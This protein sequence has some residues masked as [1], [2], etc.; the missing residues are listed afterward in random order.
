MKNTFLLWT[1]GFRI[2]QSRIWFFPFAQ[3]LWTI[4]FRILARNESL[5]SA[6]LLWSCYPWNHSIFSPLANQTLL[7]INR[8][9]QRDGKSRT[10]TTT[11]LKSGGWAWRPTQGL[12]KSGSPVLKRAFLHDQWESEIH[13]MVVILLTKTTTDYIWKWTDSLLL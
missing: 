13:Q 6:S 3:P 5:L 12:L 8:R 2:V 1:I 7:V 9:V 11:K 4:G 10:W